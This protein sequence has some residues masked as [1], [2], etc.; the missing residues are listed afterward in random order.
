MTPKIGN[1]SELENVLCDFEKT[2]KGVLDFIPAFGLGRLLCKFNTLKTKGFSV[3]MLFLTLLL[4]R[5]RGESINR[6]SDPFL[7][8][9]DDNTLYR[10]LNNPMVDWRRLLLAFA[11]QFKKQVESKGDP[12]E[13]FSCFIVDDTD[14]PKTGKTFE[15]ISRIFSHVNKK[16]NL[17]YKLLL[18]AWWDGKSLISCDFSL[19]REAGRLGN[20]GLSPK[21]RKNQFKKTRSSSCPSIARIKELDESKV[22]NTIS[23]LK[24]AVKNGFKADYVLMDSWFVT[25]FLIKSI[26]GIKNG[27]MHVLGLCKLDKRQYLI[28]NKKFNAKEL[29]VKHERKAKKYSR[30]YRS[31]YIPL[32]VD[33]KGEAVKLFFIKYNNAPHWSLLLTTDLK[34]NF[35]K[36]IER[37]Q[38]R[39]SIEVL[40]KECKQY[41]GLGRSQNTDFDGQIADTTLVFVTHTILSLQKRFGSYETMGGLFRQIQQGLLEMTL[42][43]RLMRA[44]IQLVMHLLDFLCIDVEETMR[45]ISENSHDKRFAQIMLALE[46]FSDNPEKTTYSG[47]YLYDLVYQ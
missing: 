12:H 46:E 5:L 4:L 37:Y 35:T 31:H 14:L 18:L 3:S 33:Y 20:F 6:M 30:N 27:S 26:R 40:F 17:G 21:E 7:N 47:F 44:F 23:M 8:K 29:I 43:Q 22:I 15:Y 11:K 10:I 32:V 42:W 9:V 16:C 39:W 13:G 45:K 34:L 25:D 2:N 36:A 1:L 24:R 19:H 41:L 38:I 28:Q